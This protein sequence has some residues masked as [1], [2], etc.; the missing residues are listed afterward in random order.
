MQ[1][2]KTRNQVIVEILGDSLHKGIKG[3]LKD[4]TKELPGPFKK[5]LWNLPKNVR[6]AVDNAFYKEFSTILEKLGVTNTRDIIEKIVPFDR[7]P[8]ILPLR[9]KALQETIAQ[10]D[11][12]SQGI[13]KDLPVRAGVFKAS[14]VKVL[15]SKH[16]D[17]TFVLGIDTDIGSDQQNRLQEIFNA[18]RQ[19][20][21]IKNATGER[22]FPNLLVRTN[23]AHGLTS[24]ILKLK[25]EMRVDLS[26]VFVVG[27]K[28]NVD[29]DVFGA[30]AGE[31]KAWIA[32]VDDSQAG[33]TGYVPVF[34]AATLAI[35]AYLNAEGK[36]DLDAIRYF[37]NAVAEK[38]V[39]PGMLQDMLTKRIIYILPK[40]TNFETDDLKKLYELAAQVHIA[41]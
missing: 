35:M 32:A 30:I 14:L 8:T 40:I 33:H 31:S 7:Q 9:P 20:E 5:E 12:L 3:T 25:N 18:V 34:E 26:N 38:P 37:Y 16:P 29:G 23:N 27:K 41:A 21:S 39:D 36:A 4:L 13:S 28:A 17:K 2:Q 10:S 11:D 6:T 19:V 22:L 15:S 1:S 24:D